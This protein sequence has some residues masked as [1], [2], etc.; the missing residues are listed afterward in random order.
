VVRTKA[1]T[2]RSEAN[3]ESAELAT[4]D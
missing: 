3:D 2:A 1:A 4:F